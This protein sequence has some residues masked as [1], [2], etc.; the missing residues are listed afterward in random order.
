MSRKGK[1]FLEL[2]PV[3][4][5]TQLTRLSP[6]RH[7]AGHVRFANDDSTS[8]RA[9]GPPKPDIE[10]EALCEMF[11]KARE[12]NA[13]LQ[14][15]F[16]D[17]KLSQAKSKSMCLQIRDQQDVPLA[18]LLGNQN[19]VWTLQDKWV[20]AVI[21]AHAALHCPA[22]SWLRADWSKEHVSFFRRGATQQADL[23][24][25]F[26][27][28]DF[29][30]Q[31][32]GVSLD[33]S[34]ALFEP[35]PTLLSLGILLLEVI[36][37]TAIETHHSPEDLIDGRPNEYTNLTT[38]LRLLEKSNGDLFVGY[39]K[40]VKACLEWDTANGELQHEEFARRMYEVI[41]E[42]LE[43]ELEHGFEISPDNLGLTGLKGIKV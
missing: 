38:A 42:P 27:T 26:L 39:R 12:R 41:V 6:D 31:P 5:T 28:L 17:G 43:R 16:E 25:P 22:G 33:G 10:P 32:A 37:G 13:K 2:D 23:S 21:L 30:N 9:D 7:D 29:D 24:H 40:A 18:S 4:R 35:Q 19:Q 3:Y 36:K 8:A 1:A 20:L 14:L 11:R 34:D 15:V